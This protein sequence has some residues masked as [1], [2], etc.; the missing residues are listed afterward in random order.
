MEVDE[1]EDL[2][3]TGLVEGGLDVVVQDVHLVAPHRRVTESWWWWIGDDGELG[4]CLSVLKSEDSGFLRGDSWWAID[5]SRWD[6]EKFMN[7]K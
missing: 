2:A 4:V 7:V 1:D 3:I 6:I 5:L